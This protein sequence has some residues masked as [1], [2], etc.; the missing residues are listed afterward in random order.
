MSGN[1]G[2]KE[3]MAANLR[4]LLEPTGMSIKDFS[5]KLGFK[6]TTTLGWFNAD[7]YPR[8]DKI[9]IIAHYFGVKKSDLVEEY[10]P[11]KEK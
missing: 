1:L 6:Y 3:T 10:N 4:R 5:K 11:I 2:N 9:E 8:I 7:R